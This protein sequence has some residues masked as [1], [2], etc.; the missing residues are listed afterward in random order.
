[1]EKFLNLNDLI[2]PKFIQLLYW[3]FLAIAIVAGI[4][5]MGYTDFFVGLLY[6]ISGVIFARVGC[7]LL[8]V[9]FKINDNLQKIA[10]KE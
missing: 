7:E 6:M 9:L 1:M 4:L 5:K 8:I 10:D 3:I 2:A